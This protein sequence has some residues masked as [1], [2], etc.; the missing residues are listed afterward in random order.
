MTIRERIAQIAAELAPGDAL[1]ALVRTSEMQ[2][3][4]LLPNIGQARRSAEMAYRRTLADMR[5]QHE[6][7][8]RAQIEAEATD[9]YAR[10]LDAKGVEHEV[11]QLIITCRGHLRS[12][13][14]EMRLSGR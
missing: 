1:P 13:D 9:E 4:A 6:K 2:L 12:L 10:L 3:S 11:E 8:N 7:A 14:T 5:R